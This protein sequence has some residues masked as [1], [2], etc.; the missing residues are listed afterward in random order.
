MTKTE[1]I[2]YVY[3]ALL[4]KVSDITYVVGG[5]SSTVVTAPNHDKSATSIKSQW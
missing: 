2:T 4:L 5:I 1:Q 3:Y